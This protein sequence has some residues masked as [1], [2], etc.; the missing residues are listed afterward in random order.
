MVI[1]ENGFMVCCGLAIGMI[2]A[3]IAI[4]PALGSRG[5]HLPGVSLPLLAVVLVVGLSASVAAT[6]ASL[7]SPLIPALRAE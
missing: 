1:A 7:R 4:V 5:G 2:C 6:I 3:L